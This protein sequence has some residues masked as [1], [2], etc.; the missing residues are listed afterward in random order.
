MHI[1]ESNWKI[2]VGNLAWDFNDYYL[3]HFYKTMPMERELP[4]TLEKFPATNTI[5]VGHDFFPKFWDWMSM[6]FIQPDK[7]NPIT[8]KTIKYFEHRIARNPFIPNEG[9]SL[10][11]RERIHDEYTA[12]LHW[13]NF[14][15]QVT[16]TSCKRPVIYMERGN[17]ALDIYSGTRTNKVYFATS[18]IHS[19]VSMDMSVE[20]H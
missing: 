12:L 17:P 10:D 8:D 20:M 3:R 9:K 14:W 4:Q 2:S 13:M 6:P 5:Y 11:E 18:V 1:I 19:S 16:K 7:P 15:V